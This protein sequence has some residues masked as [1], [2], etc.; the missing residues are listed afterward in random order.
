M[1]NSTRAG[2]SSVTDPRSTRAAVT[3]VL[4]A[5]A[6][7]T[8]IGCGEYRPPT[9][10]T[11]VTPAPSSPPSPPS[12]QGPVP[13]TATVPAASHGEF[14]VYRS[15]VT[16][17]RGGTARVSLTWPNLDFSLQ[18][19]VTGGACPDIT[20]LVTGGCNVVGSTRLGL[21][22][23]VTSPVTAGDLH[24]IWVLNPDP[25][26]QDFRVDVSID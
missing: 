18:L 20:S 2:F 14:G 11:F 21:P 19:H 13:A 23:V 4:V 9:A 22:G 26:P 1:T 7:T 25:Y 3:A 8:S 12:P 10:P 24:T 15:D 17:S 16:M 6:L 5:T